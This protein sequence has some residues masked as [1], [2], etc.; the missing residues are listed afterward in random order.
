[1][2]AIHGVAEIII[3]KHRHGPTGTVELA[4]IG[5]LTKFGNLAKADRVP[6][7]PF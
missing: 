7:V 4:F 6:N 5:E 1:M 2:E 3:G